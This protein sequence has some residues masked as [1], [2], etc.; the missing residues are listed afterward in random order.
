MRLALLP[1]Q[2]SDISICHHYLTE[3]NKSMQIIQFQFSVMIQ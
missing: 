3:E 2:V 1:E